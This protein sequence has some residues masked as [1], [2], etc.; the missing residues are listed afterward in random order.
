MKG[1]QIVL[2]SSLFIT[3]FNDE[4]GNSSFP[5]TIIRAEE[6]IDSGNRKFY[7]IYEPSSFQKNWPSL[8]IYSLKKLPDE[9]Q[10]LEPGKVT[11]DTFY[12]IHMLLYEK[13]GWLQDEFVKSIKRNVTYP[14]TSDSHDLDKHSYSLSYIKDQ[15]KI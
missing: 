3:Q 6:K 4:Y 14:D 11:N 9:L 7:E 2:M 12:N 10:H 15:L 13:A 5:K 1:I 8:G